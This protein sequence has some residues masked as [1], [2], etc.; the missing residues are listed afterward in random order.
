MN[1]IFLVPGIEGSRL[2]L[3]TEEVWPPTVGELISGY[4]RIDKLI[5]PSVIATGIWDEIVIGGLIHYPVYKPIM[6]KL[7]EIAGELNA[8]RVNFF[9]DW[10]TY[11]W[12]STPPFTASSERLAQA[13][14]SAVSSGASS[15][16]LVCH[17]M[18]SLVARLVIESSKY[19]NTNWFSKIKKVVFICGPNLGAPVAVGRA[20]A[21]EGSSLGLTA[22]QL[23]LI[24]NDPRYPAGFK[25]FTEPGIDTLYDVSSGSAVPVDIYSA[26]AD[27]RYQLNRSNAQAATVSW[28]ELKDIDSHPKTIEYTAI[29][30]TG[31]TTSN[32]YLFNGPRY[33]ETITGDG[34][35]TVP[36]WSASAGKYAVHYT[37]Q[38]SHVDI[39]GTPALKQTLD[40]IFGI[41]VVSAFVQAAPGVTVNVNKKTFK[42]DE[43]MEILVIPD[44]PTT[45]INGHLKLKFVDASRVKKAANLV[46]YGTG[47]S[48]TYKGPA[49]THF[50]AKLTAPHVPG[51]YILAFEGT[52]KSSEASSAVFFVNAA[53]PVTVHSGDKSSGGPAGSAPTR[54]APRK[55]KSKRKS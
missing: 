54:Q 26:A 35:G 5:N 34:D 16:T 20:L 30:G 23:Q 49:T 1:C 14:E 33:V 39:L 47:T 6:D 22:A 46:P 48:L 19:R 50:L 31:L 17:S 21:C 42:P 36:I 3:G 44:A 55:S 43:P 11:L 2:S 41:A 37:L 52:H 24:E 8:K 10:R 4:N 15:V 53:T 12:K 25:C 45:D 13:I 28:A 9:Y 7:D 32:S 18:G 38:G 27:T 29:A 51:A 40:K